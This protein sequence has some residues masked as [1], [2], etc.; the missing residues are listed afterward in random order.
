MRGGVPG[1]VAQAIPQIDAEIAEKGHLWINTNLSSGAC[2][3]LSMAV[4][5][6]RPS[7]GCE[8][9]VLVVVDEQ[10]QTAGYFIDWTHTPYEPGGDWLPVRASDHPLVA[11]MEFEDA[12]CR[13]PAEAPST[14]IPLLLAG[15][16][17]PLSRAEAGFAARAPRC[18]PGCGP[19][20]PR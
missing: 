12:V 18:R 19:R 17:R 2:K 1:Y 3:T 16:R 14:G 20:P 6:R 9:L 5:G 13:A 15:R 10:E 4:F 7:D 11:G 8:V